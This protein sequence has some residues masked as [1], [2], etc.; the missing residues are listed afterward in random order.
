[1]VP[2]YNLSGIPSGLKF[3]G[4]VLGEIY[5]GKIKTW[6]DP[7]LTALNPGVNLP[8]EPIAV[9]HRSDSSGTT[10][11]WTN[12]LTK[13]SPAW[14][15]ALGGSAF[16]QGK[17]VAWPVGIGGRATRA[18]PLWSA[19]PQ[20]RSG[21]SKRTT[22]SRSRLSPA[23]LKRIAAP[24]SGHRRLAAPGP[25]PLPWPRAGRRGRPAPSPAWRSLP[26][27]LAALRGGIGRCG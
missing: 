11:I 21:T 5:A 3:T 18:S 8:D 17:T 19:R 13:T 7:A 10:G 4:N 6:N 26:L 14:V 25:Q 23:G 2:G 1:V 9:V 24:A 12:Y 16:S 15:S 22:R 20:A 27:A